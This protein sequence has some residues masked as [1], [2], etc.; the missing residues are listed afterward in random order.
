MWKQL[1]NLFYL[2]GRTPWDTEVTPP[3]LI[4]VVE[5]GQIPPGRALD[6]GCGTGTN[7]IYLAQHSFEAVGVD[8]AYLAIWRARY[9]A[10]REKT[11]VKFYTGDVLKLGM[12]R[13]LIIPVPVD[14]VLDIGCLHSLIEK[15]LYSY[16]EML[17]RV[18][19]I[20]GFY[21]LYAWGPRELHGRSIGLSPDKIRATLGN[22]LHNQWIREGE[23][24]GAPS[25]W[26][27]F[28]RLS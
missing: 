14:F 11:P 21:M 13:G 16:T 19:R 5:R 15:Q 20:G 1:W 7:A 17:W 28:E 24:G 3:E 23:E 4:E 22:S 9:K 27:L 12:K 6:I 10:W 26:Y 25:Y 8:I 2:L 18:L